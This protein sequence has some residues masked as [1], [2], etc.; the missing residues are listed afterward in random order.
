MAHRGAARPKLDVSVPVRFT[1]L[2]LW[3]VVSGSRAICTKSVT[4]AGPEGNDG[5]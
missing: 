1:R 2:H 4:F 5:W 3:P